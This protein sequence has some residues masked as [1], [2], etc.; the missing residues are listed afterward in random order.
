MQRADCGRRQRLPRRRP[1]LG[2]EGA[3]RPVL[4]GRSPRR[5]PRRVR[6][7]AWGNGEHMRILTT[8]A[9]SSLLSVG[10][11]RMLGCRSVEG[12]GADG[13]AAVEQSSERFDAR[14]IDCAI[15]IRPNRPAE[16]V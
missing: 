16:W 12:A 2:A 14:A 6:R 4:V 1:V 15:V 11:D 5:G 10:G 9:I 3:A 7:G 8:L 13:D